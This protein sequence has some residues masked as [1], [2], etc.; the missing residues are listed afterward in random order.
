[1]PLHRIAIVGAPN[2]GKSTL[3][4][5]LVR[6]RRSLVAAE[7][8]LT[9][10]LI[11]AEARLPGGGILL[12]DT[13]GLLPPEASHLAVEIRR[14]VLEAAR[15]CQLLLFVTDARAGCTGMDEELALLFRKSG[16]PVL[17]VVNKVD[18]P[19]DGL[20]AAS[21][22]GLGFDQSVSI[23]AEHNRGIDLLKEILSSLLP[24]SG[25]PEEREEEILIALAGRPN[26]GKSSLLNAFLQEERAL[27]SSEPGTTRDPVEG[28]LVRKGRRFRLIDTAGMRRRSR[29]DEGAEALSVGAARRSMRRADVT[30]VLVD[31]SDGIVAQDL[32]VFGMIAAGG[33]RWR[34]PVVVLLNKVDLLA[35]PDEIR[36]RMEELRRR[37]QFARF[38]PILAISATTD[39]RL[40]AVLESAAGV[41]DQSM[42]VLPA[43]ELNDWLREALEKHPAPL[44]GGSPLS[45]VFVSQAST[46]PPTF[47][48]LTNRKVRPHPSYARYLENS[49]RERFGLEGTPLVLRFRPKGRGTGRSGARMR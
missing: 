2:V 24:D 14:R 1:M 8:G 49:L 4:N 43:R 37:L 45:M 40:G 6:R 31:A 5:R 22:A 29:I 28:L 34:R 27:V 47:T 25:E 36:G 32:H 39:P 33:S 9:R 41:H 13:G 35:G 20:A 42:R 46:R 7:P 19:D 3:F 17:L 48:I 44:V 21:F 16:R 38:A 15:D 26:V 12:V 23:S 18:H 30:L 11:E 10:D